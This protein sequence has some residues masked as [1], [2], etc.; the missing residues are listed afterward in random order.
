MDEFE[1]D[2][3]KRLINRAKHG[4]DFSQVVDFDF[5]TAIHE[6]DRRGDYGEERVI[7]TG[8]LL[9]RLCVL[10]WTNRSGRYRIISLRKANDREEK[11][12]S[13]TAR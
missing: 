1:W 2:E 7:S 6:P 11:I 4:L 13:G 9:G 10:F 12:F 5:E 8:Y 3:R